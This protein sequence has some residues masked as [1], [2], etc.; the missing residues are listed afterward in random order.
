MKQLFEMLA[1]LVGMYVVYALTMGK[2]NYTSQARQEQRKTQG[3]AVG[4]FLFYASAYAVF[5]N[6]G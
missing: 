2:W 3:G 6:A 1:V 4:T 5:A